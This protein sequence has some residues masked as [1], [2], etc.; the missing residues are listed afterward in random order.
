MVLRGIVKRKAFFVIS[1]VHL[2][3]LHVW[4]LGDYFSIAIT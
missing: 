2:F 4:A 3:Q 1:E